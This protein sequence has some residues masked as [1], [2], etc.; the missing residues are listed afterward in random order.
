MNPNANHDENSTEAE[1]VITQEMIDIARESIQSEEDYGYTPS[2]PVRNRLS[3]FKIISTII[4]LI[5]NLIG[6]NK[7]STSPGS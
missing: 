7:A 4:M 3:L 2:Q 5:V 1:F 6:M